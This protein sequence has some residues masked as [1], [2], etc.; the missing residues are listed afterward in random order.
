[1]VRDASPT[2]RPRRELYAKAHELAGDKPVVFRT[3]DVGGDKVL[4]Y[5]QLP[6]RGQPGDGLARDAHRARPAGDAAPAAARADAQ[7]RRAGRS[8]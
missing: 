5:W 1:M 6:E 2:S 7:R 4:P 8:T 3:L